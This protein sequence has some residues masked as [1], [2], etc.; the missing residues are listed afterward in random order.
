MRVLTFLL[1]SVCQSLL[2][3]NGWQEMSGDKY[4]PLVGDYWIVTCM[5]DSTCEGRVQEQ[6]TSE[7]LILELGQETGVILTIPRSQIRR[8]QFYRPIY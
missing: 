1:L 5:N 7:K 4:H 8:I 3:C 6:S 2:G